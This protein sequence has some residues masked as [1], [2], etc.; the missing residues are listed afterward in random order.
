MPT[1]IRFPLDRLRQGK[2]LLLFAALSCGGGADGGSTP[3][4]PARVLSR[5]TGDAQTAAAGD[6]VPV[7]PRIRV[8]TTAGAPVAGVVV[9]FAVGTGGG[10]VAGAAATSDANGEAAVGS[11]SLGVGTGE[12]TL[13]ASVPGATPGTVSFTATAIAGPA[14]TLGKVAGDNQRAVAR[15]AVS[16]R[17]A[18][19]VVDRHNNAIAGTVVTFSVVAGGGSVTGATP[20]T[21]A[22]GVATLGAWTLGSAGPQRLRAAVGTGSAAPVEFAAT[23]DE[24]LLAPARDTTLS[25]TVRVTRVDLSADR[26]ITIGSGGLR[27]EADSTI[28]I[29]GKILGACHGLALVARDDVTITGTL[30]N[31]CATPNDS[32]PSLQVLAGQDVAFTGATVVSSGDIDVTNDS[33]L[34]EG[35]FPMA[36]AHRGSATTAAA[37]RICAATGSFRFRPDTA[38]RGASGRF[39]SPGGTGRTMR[40]RCNG[41]LVLSGAS[42]V[43]QHGGSGGDGTDTSNRPADASGGDGG[44]GGDVRLWATG[45]LSIAGATIEGGR[46]GRGGSALA[47]GTPSTVGSRA[48]DAT[49]RAGDGAPGG[50]FDLRAGVEVQFQST[51]TVRVGRAGDGG[52]AVATGAD[53]TAP[54]QDGG[55][56][57]ARGGTGGSSQDKQL[58]APG[59]LNPHLATLRGGEGGNGGSAEAVG[60]NGASGSMPLPNS[61]A[62]GDM[63]ATGG[64]G[65]NALLRDLGGALFAMGGNGG[66][67]RFVNGIGAEGWT[68]RCDAPGGFLPG[69]NGGNGGAARGTD[70]AGGTPN[71]APG[72]LHYAARVGNAGVG[73]QGEA[74][75]ATGTTTDAVT[76]RGTRTR[77]APLGFTRPIPFP[78]VNVSQTHFD[79]PFTTN[80]LCQSPALVRPLGVSNFGAAPVTAAVTVVNPGG[81]FHDLFV[82]DAVSGNPYVTGQLPPDNATTGQGPR[83]NVRRSCGGTASPAFYCVRLALT[84]AATTRVYRLPWRM[85]SAATP[86][87]VAADIAACAAIP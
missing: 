18:V 84:V 82:F 13:T 4:P 49:A 24:V 9:T 50:R 15:T 7:P 87:T 38:R 57:T 68:N 10:T 83:I 42:I 59:V 25:G 23:G 58:R 80:E 61:G 73:G 6:P 81:P 70:G 20:V 56:A 45:V 78:C 16:Q 52:N 31:S 12:N 53:G 29:A 67:A 39:G 5:V 33:T 62:G 41:D 17:P 37:G 1:P 30:D 8:S 74:P 72:N 65:G 54:A 36:A 63:T 43:A 3:P 69:G 2:V 47:Q 27:I 60:G 48:T 66:M 76:V 79:V 40:Y 19:K 71:G 51:S 14:A 28:T 55:H 85:R 44:R 75:G 77:V 22:D 64:D 46:G 11:W 26:T 32:A 21:G 34:T 86:A 35:S